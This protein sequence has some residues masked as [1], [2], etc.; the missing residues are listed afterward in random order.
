MRGVNVLVAKWATTFAK[1]SAFLSLVNTWIPCLIH[2][3]PSSSTFNFFRA[4]DDNSFVGR[5]LPED[6]AWTR[7][8]RISFDAFGASGRGAS[9]RG[10]SGRGASG[11]TF[12]ALGSAFGSGRTFGA[13]GRTFGASTKM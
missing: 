5:S 6:L 10:A 9:G 7:Q 13:S 8:Y 3:S 4:A 11:R 1:I 12:G 2:N